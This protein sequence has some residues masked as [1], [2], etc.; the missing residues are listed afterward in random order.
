MHRGSPSI[1]PHDWLSAALSCWF[2]V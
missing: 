2:A 1:S